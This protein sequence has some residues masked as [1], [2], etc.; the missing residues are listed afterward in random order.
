MTDVELTKWCARAM[1]FKI[2]Y[3]DQAD[4]PLCTEGPRGSGVYDPLH[5]DDQAMALVKDFTLDIEPQKEGGGGSWMV[6]LWSDGQRYGNVYDE[7]LNRAIVKCVAKEQQRLE[8]ATKRID[9]KASGP[10]FNTE[11]NLH[12]DTVVERFDSAHDGDNDGR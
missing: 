8:S 9:R 5:G 12:A 3:P 4:L 6:S 2:I 10:D 11:S 7:N 1:G